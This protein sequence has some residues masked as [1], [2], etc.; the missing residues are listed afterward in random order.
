[1]EAVVF[2]SDM[3]NPVVFSDWMLEPP[4]LIASIVRLFR[5]YLAGYACF[6]GGQ[7][8]DLRDFVDYFAGGKIIDVRMVNDPL[9]RILFVVCRNNLPH[10]PIK[11]LENTLT[12]SGAGRSIQA[13]IAGHSMETVVRELNACVPPSHNITSP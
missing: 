8:D 2:N 1:L 10:A 5:T 3:V 4:A 12:C 13:M 7:Q 9:T 6:I 11:W